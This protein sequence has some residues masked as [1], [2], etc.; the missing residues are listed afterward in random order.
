MP[1]AHRARVKAHV[2]SPDKTRGTVWL[3]ETEAGVFTASITAGQTGVY[4][5]HFIAEGGTSRGAPFTREQLATAAVW[6]GADRPAE[7]PTGPAGGGEG[8]DWCHLL[9]CLL[10]EKNLSRELEER[11]QRQGIS[12]AGMR[13]CLKRACSGRARVSA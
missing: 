10:S 6:P 3:A 13:A 4:T 11:L 1:L 9:E 7:P 2:D 8:I 12:V 5:I